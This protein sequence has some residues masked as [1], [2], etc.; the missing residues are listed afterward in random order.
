MANDIKVTVA[1]SAGF[2]F[3][4]SRAASAVEKEIETATGGERI[5]TLGKLIHNDTYNA[6]LASRGVGVAEIGDIERL[7]AEACADAPVRVFVRAHGITKETEELLIKCSK[8]NEHFSFVDC[9]CVFVQKIHKIVAE[10]ND[11]E[12][13]LLV[14]GS[15]DH[16]EVMG[17]CSRFSGRV[18]VSW[19]G[20]A[21]P[22][23]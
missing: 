8:Q 1:K 17:F 15:A 11:P 16:P 9:T 18:A 10:N 12:G 6:R 13:L 20:T 2:C 19:K 7:C 21:S 4:V 23:S 22:I 3:G 14:L 5:F